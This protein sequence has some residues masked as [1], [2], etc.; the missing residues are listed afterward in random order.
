LGKKS[1]LMP[2][3]EIFIG[4][5]GPLHQRGEARAIRFGLGE[6]KKQ[7]IT[8][9]PATNSTGNRERGN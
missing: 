3:R 5:S 8:A 1:G 2:M 6:K 4:K 7:P 9:T